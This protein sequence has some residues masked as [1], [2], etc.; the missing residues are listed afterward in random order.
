MLDAYQQLV[1]IGVAGE[2]YI[3]GPG[4][5]PGYWKRPE[6]T[7]ERF[8][9]NPFGAGRLYRTGDRVRWR[10]DGR[11]EFLGRVDNQVK[12]RGHRIE[13]GEIERQLMRIPAIQE[14]VVLADED[15]GLLAWMTTT[16]DF[17]PQAAWQW[18]RQQLPSYM[19]PARLV[20]IDSFPRLPN[21]KLDRQQLVRLQ[22]PSPE[23]TQP[24]EPQNELESQLLAI[25]RQVLKQPGLRPSDDFFRHGGDSLQS[26]RVIAQ[27]QQANIP[28]SPNLLFEYP[29][30]RELATYLQSEARA[31]PTWESVSRLAQGS[32]QNPP[33]FC[34]HSGAA[35]VFFYR[36]L[37]N[38]LREDYTV[39]ALQAQGLDKDGQLPSSIEEMAAH[40]I[41]EIK[42]V[43]AQGPYRLLGTCFSNA[44]GLE[45]AHQLQ[46]KGDH[47]DRLIFVDSGPAH[48]QSLRT[49]E[50]K[51]TWHRLGQMLKTG[52]WRGISK[53]IRNRSI[54]AARQISQPF[55]SAS[56]Q[57]LQT[58]IDNLNDLYARYNWEPY[59]G[60][61]HFIRSSE[62]AARP[63]KDYH[64][65]QWTKLTRGQLH[66]YIVPG[67]HLTLF[68]EPEVQALAAV[69]HDILR[70][71]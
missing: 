56:A 35:H 66:Q 12:I 64:L 11:L 71:E 37:A 23:N 46:A 32:T 34:I 6:L 26:I 41:A 31:E 28:L 42:R 33:L 10:A 8:L 15:H 24:D 68:A 60:D 3:G 67:H 7:K 22:S 47:I 49:T 43:Q 2:L 17:E 55:K 13:L 65:E 9:D 27:A 19:L 21:G 48:L 51:R 59:P 69:I 52:D 58:T 1:P 57:R 50:G 4:L 29:T 5:S 30:V 39:Y 18:L 36:E 14:A 16:T 45:M 54:V 70:G 38:Y 53:K 63:D 44:V 20:R 40:Y 61:I 25:W 62:F